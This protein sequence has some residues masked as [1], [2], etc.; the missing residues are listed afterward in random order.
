E[1]G[2]RLRSLDVRLP[3]GGE[4]GSRRSAGRAGSSAAEPDDRIADRVEH[5]GVAERLSHERLR[6]VPLAAADERRHELL[7]R[8]GEID[9]HPAGGIAARE[10]P[11]LAVEVRLIRVPR[12]VDADLAAELLVASD[13]QLLERRTEGVVPRADIEL[14][15]L[16]EGVDRGLR[17]QFALQRVGGIGAPE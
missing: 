2:V 12:D 3:V 10:L 14:R 13:E 1:A 8:L 9:D 16:A 4:R 11:R 15:A 6:G 5:R 7:E 17:E